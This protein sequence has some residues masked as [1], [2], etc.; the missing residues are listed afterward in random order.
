MGYVQIKVKAPFVPVQYK[1][2]APSVFLR[3]ANFLLF[4]YLLGNELTQSISLKVLFNYENV[5]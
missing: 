3:I 4:F 2:K 5:I 1:V